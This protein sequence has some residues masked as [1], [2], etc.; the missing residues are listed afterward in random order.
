VKEEDGRERKKGRE[1]KTDLS[2]LGF[3]SSRLTLCQARTCTTSGCAGEL[4]AQFTPG[5]SRSRCAS[6]RR[7]SC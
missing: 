2:D 3:Y 7:R 1:G 6:G 4:L 5:G